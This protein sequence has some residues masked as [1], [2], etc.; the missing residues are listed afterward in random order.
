MLRTKKGPTQTV[1]P[2]NELATAKGRTKTH[3]LKE[4]IAE[5]L[6]QLMGGLDLLTF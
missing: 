4:T 2:A 1:Q 3:I 5:I 6:G